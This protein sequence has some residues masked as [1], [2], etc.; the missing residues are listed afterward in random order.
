MV[1]RKKKHCL[2]MF[3]EFRVVLILQ[4]VSTT[5]TH[6]YTLHIGKQLIGDA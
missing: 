6:T 3:E 4:I 5:H 2:T 1:K